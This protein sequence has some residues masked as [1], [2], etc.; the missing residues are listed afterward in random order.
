[1]QTQSTDQNSG[2]MNNEKFNE[3]SYKE[4]SDG[5]IKHWQEVNTPPDGM[6]IENPDPRIPENKNAEIQTTNQEDMKTYT[7]PMHP[8][9]NTSKPGRCPNCGMELI[10]K[11]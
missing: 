1:M 4:A 11:K 5:I 6:E 3:A 7:C 9:V 10:E 2:S 8:E